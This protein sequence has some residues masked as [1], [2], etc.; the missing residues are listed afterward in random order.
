MG[1][2]WGDAVSGIGNGEAGVGIVRGDDGEELPGMR[3]LRPRCPV[4]GRGPDRTGPDLRPSISHPQLSIPTLKSP[5][6]SDINPLPPPPASRFASHSPRSGSAVGFA[7]RVRGG[8]SARVGV[9]LGVGVRV[10]ALRVPRAEAHFP[11]NF[12]FLKCVPRGTL[13]RRVTCAIPPPLSRP[14]PGPKLL[15]LPVPSQP[16]HSPHTNHPSPF[17]RHPLSPTAPLTR[18]SCRLEA[19]LFAG[20]EGRRIALHRSWSITHHRRQITDH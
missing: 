7:A 18:H 6:G 9:G 5:R 13:P 19:K 1:G 10:G 3:P 11:E 17:A 15:P 8:A 4:W 2:P 16:H 12:A 14:G 20:T